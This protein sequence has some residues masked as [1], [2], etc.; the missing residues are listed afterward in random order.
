MTPSISRRILA[1]ALT[2]FTATM[3]AV[4][5]AAA[6]EQAVFSGRVLS[7]DGVTPRGGVVVSLLNVETR[8]TFSSTPTGDEG[9]FH[10]DTAPAGSYQVAAETPDGAFVAPGTF[11]LQAGAN[12]PLAFKLAPTASVAPAQSGGGG[13]DHSIWQYV[14]GS[15]VFIGALFVIDDSGED[16]EEDASAF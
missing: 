13:P 11:E 7:P 12:K 1:L 16:V 9:A 2:L 4:V 10:I 5:P 6:T 8:E 3:S 14:V 15:L